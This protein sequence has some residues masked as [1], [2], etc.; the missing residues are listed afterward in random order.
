MYT[1]INDNTITIFLDKNN[2]TIEH[3]I[4][5]SHINNITELSIEILK[6]LKLNWINVQ[7]IEE[8][9]EKVKQQKSINSKILIVNTIKRNTDSY[10]GLRL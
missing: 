1:K 10:V 7:I 3:I 9:I 4:N 6:L 2:Q 5:I 8:I